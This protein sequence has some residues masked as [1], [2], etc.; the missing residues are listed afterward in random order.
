MDRTSG[1][2]PEDEGSNPSGDVIGANVPRL[3]DPDSKSR[4]VGSIPTASVQIPSVEKISSMVEKRGN[5][6]KDEEKI[7]F[8]S[9]WLYNT[10]LL[11]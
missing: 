11:F 2:G 9:F 8:C 10:I 7:Y 4:W 6:D 5:Y 1:Y 3:G